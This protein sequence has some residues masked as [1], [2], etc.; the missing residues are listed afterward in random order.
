MIKPD[1]V[2][3]AIPGKDS[4]KIKPASLPGFD[5][6]CPGRAVCESH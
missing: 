5:L 4:L 3:A 2:S 1:A 6:T